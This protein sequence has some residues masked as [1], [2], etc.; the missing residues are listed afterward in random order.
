MPRS[1]GACIS[2]ILLSASTGMHILYV[3][4]YTC[5]PQCHRPCISTEH[6]SLS[7]TTHSV[8]TLLVVLPQ[9]GTSNSCPLL[10][11]TSP[12]FDCG[13]SELHCSTATD[14]IAHT[15]IN[16][17]INILDAHSPSTYGCS[18]HSSSSSTMSPLCSPEQKLPTYEVRLHSGCV[19]LDTPLNMLLATLFSRQAPLSACVRGR[20]S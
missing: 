11:F 6:Q 7:Y 2:N 13:A 16:C 18:Q 12:D 17:E 15:C 4:M 3:C 10:T 5:T 8:H 9:T 14:P 20:V 19:N 1:L